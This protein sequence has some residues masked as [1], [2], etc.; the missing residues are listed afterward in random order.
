M[1]RES[2]MYEQIIEQLD[3]IEAKE[4]LQ[5]Y[6]DLFDVN[7]GLHDVEWDRTGEPK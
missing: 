1:L 7:Y 3:S 2:D 4:F 5:L 6:N